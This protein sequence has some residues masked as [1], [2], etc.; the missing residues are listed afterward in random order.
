VIAYGGVQVGRLDARGAPALLMNLVGAILVLLSLTHTFNLA[1]YAGVQ[2]EKLDPHAAP[3]L[4]L[5]F[6]GAVLILISLV[7]DFNLAA[8]LLEGAWGLIS[9]Y[10]LGKLVARR[11]RLSR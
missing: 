7:H 3:A 6:A 1:A 4:L 5:N 9:L 2:V 8:F 10:G 11:R